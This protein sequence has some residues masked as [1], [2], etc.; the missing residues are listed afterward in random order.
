LGV[1]RGPWGTALLVVVWALALAGVG[2]KVMVGPDG[3]RKLGTSLY[4]ALGWV[5]LLAAG[6]ILRLVAPAGLAWLLAG[7]AAYTLGVAFFRAEQVR[8]AHFIWHLLV[9]AG[10]I[11]HFIAILLYAAR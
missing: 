1:L 5:L 4:L 6:P 3:H 11:C 8:Y 2:F 10:T 7:G 9:L